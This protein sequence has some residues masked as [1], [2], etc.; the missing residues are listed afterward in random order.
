MIK[1]WPV[2]RNGDHQSDLHRAV[3]GAGLAGKP[4]ILTPVATPLKVVRESSAVLDPL[5]L[6]LDCIIISFMRDNRLEGLR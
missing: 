5:K 3:E 2:T 4:K 6:S 1:S